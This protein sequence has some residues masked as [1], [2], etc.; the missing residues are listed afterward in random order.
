[1]RPR[2]GSK[3]SLSN[4]LR[5]NSSG[6]RSRDCAVAIF[7]R[8]PR[9]GFCKTRLIP[10]LGV[11]GA[12]ELQGALISDTL[13]KVK[14][15]HRRAAVYLIKT[16]RAPDAAGFPGWPGAPV[17]VLSQRGND[18]GERLNQAFGYLLRLYR[19]VVVTGTDSPELPAQ[20]LLQALE[21]L[22]WCEAVLGPCHDGGY[23]LIGLRRE[24]GAKKRARLLL[25]DIRW[26]TRWALED[27]LRNLV[28]GGVSCFMLSPARDIDRP[29]DFIALCRRMQK[30]A[31]ARRIAPATWRFARTF[32]IR[33]IRKS[34][35]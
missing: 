16:G 4:V 26:G 29:A 35:Y 19:R 14:A 12:A 27:T 5:K 31:A 33:A 13:A 34:E 1:M 21:E 32:D 9:A 11:Q 15:L 6:L 7:A 17:H 28:S 24:A 18:L 8:S 3:K 10:L 2:S 25:R 30:N 22:R 23:Y 20:N